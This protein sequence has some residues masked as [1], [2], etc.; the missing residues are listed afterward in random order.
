[1]SSISDS[2]E[3]AR[4]VRICQ[5]IVGALLMGTLTF[6]GILFVIRT[7]PTPG[8]LSYVCLGF[9]LIQITARTVVLKVID[10]S[11]VKRAARASP[12]VALQQLLAIYQTRTLIGAA[13]LE[14]LAFFACICYLLER[15]PAVLAV[16]AICVAGLLVQMP[17]IS[18]ATAWIETQ[19]KAI[20]AQRGAKS[21]TP[22]AVNW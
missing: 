19:L 12:E 4:T 20:D 6:L 10:A 9:A 13:L 2:P 1:M 21:D 3:L 15:Q 14:G 7:V 18:K 11:A 22:P 17:S 5:V 8:I 16:I